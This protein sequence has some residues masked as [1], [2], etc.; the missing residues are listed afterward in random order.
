M[1]GAARRAI[2]ATGSDYT[3]RNA[4]GGSGGRDVP[5]YSDDGTLTAV[6][7]RRGQAAPVTTS[8]GTE[9]ETDLELRAVT[10]SGTT[11][12]E[13]GSS[14]GYPTRLEHPD[15]LTY[16]V[17]EQHPEDGGVTVLLVVRD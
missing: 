10:T 11:I 4:T 9:I 17:M 6:L 12:R 1:N 8:D 13:A 5:S 3:I 14:G 15:G 2:A 16:R 7:E